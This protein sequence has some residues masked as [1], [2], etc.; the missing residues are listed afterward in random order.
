MSRPWLRRLALM[1]ASVSL[2]PAAALPAL[3]WRT[4]QASL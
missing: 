2:I 3:Q 1:E 4:H